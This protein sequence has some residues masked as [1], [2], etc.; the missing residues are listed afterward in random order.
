ML[1]VVHYIQDIR[2]NDPY[3]HR[4]SVMLEQTLCTGRREE[5]ELSQCEVEEKFRLV[6]LV[7]IPTEA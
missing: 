7:R 3:D 2:S 5:K 4:S 6:K 1:S